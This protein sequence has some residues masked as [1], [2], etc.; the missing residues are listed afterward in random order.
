MNKKFF[1]TGFIIGVFTFINLLNSLEYLDFI[2]SIKW[3]M[4]FALHGSILIGFIILIVLDCKSQES[5]IL[6]I[7]SKIKSV[8]IPRFAKGLFIFIFFMEFIHIAIGKTIYP[9]ADVGMFRYSR[10]KETKFNPIVTIPKYYYFKEDQPR[11]VEIR[12]QHLFFLSDLLGLG[13]N[14]EYTFSAAYHYKGL[15]ENYEFLKSALI[16]Q[17][18][19]DTLW[20]GLHEVD[21]T[22]GAVTFDPD[23]KRATVFND[24]AKIFYGPIFIPSHQKI[25]ANEME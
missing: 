6:K 4:F 18:D 25:K 22:T 14:N 5:L 17:Q 1:L 15:E 19:I 9:F 23:I 3:K 8:P 13:Y 24:T 16:E 12:K 7:Y 20:V 10:P 11:I 2:G 21:Y